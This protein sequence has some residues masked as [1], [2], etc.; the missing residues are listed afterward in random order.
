MQPKFFLT[1]AELPT[2]SL[3]VD[4]RET[5]AEWLTENKWFTT[6]AANRMWAEL[7]GEGFYEPVDD[8]GPDRE[9]RAPDTLKILVQGFRQS[10]HDVKWLIETICATEAYQRQ[11]RPRGVSDEH[12]PFAASVPQPLR[13]DQLYNVVL[14]ALDVPDEAPRGP[15]RKAGAAYGRQAGRRG[16]FNL[17]FG[18]DP[19]EPRETITGSIP[20]T[21]AL[22]NSSQVSGALNGN[23]GVLGGLLKE[24]QDNEELFVELYLRM[25]SRQPTD[26]ELAR[27]LAYVDEVGNRKAAVEDLAWALVN[28]AESRHR[29]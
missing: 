12:V 3:D 6:A 14:S 22:M 24:I 2:G 13:A 9:P 29:R 7:V 18:Y 10:G 20:Q 17:T 11:S 16:Q 25:L 15:L 28:S 5:I 23:R 27:A 26:D 21:L 19:S 1:S 4:R 8:I